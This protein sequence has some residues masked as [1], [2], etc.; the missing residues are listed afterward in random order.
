MQP[1]ST[2]THAVARRL[3]GSYSLNLLADGETVIVSCLTGAFINI[4]SVSGTKNRIEESRRDCSIVIASRGSVKGATVLERA[5]P[6]IKQRPL[7]QVS[8]CA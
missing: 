8:L 6:L 1:S 3:S 7:Q 5:A 2:G 4:A